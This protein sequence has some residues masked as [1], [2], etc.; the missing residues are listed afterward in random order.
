MSKTTTL[1][2]LSCSAS[3]RQAQSHGRSSSQSFHDSASLNGD[4]CPEQTGIENGLT[5][6]DASVLSTTKTAEVPDE[7]QILTS[8]LTTSTAADYLSSASPLPLSVKQTV[9]RLGSFLTNWNFNRNN[10][11]TVCYFCWSWNGRRIRDFT[12]LELAHNGQMDSSCCIRIQDTFPQT[13]VS[14]ADSSD[15]CPERTADGANE[16]GD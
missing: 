10:T 3:R 9:I 15:S 14:V 4:S 2:P 11:Q 16:G 7:R 8:Q 12:K 1:P 13:P 6:L 5:S